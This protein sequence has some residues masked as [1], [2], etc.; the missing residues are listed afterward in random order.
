VNALGVVLD[1]HALVDAFS[2][3]LKPGRVHAVVGESGSGKTLSALAVLGLLPDGAT[4]R[5]SAKRGAIELLSASDSVRRKGIAMVLQEPLSSLNPVLSVGAQLLETLAVHGAGGDRRALALALLA[6]VGIPSGE[7]RLKMFPHQLSGGQRQRVS[8]ALALAAS[9]EV[10]IADEPTTALDA[11]MRGVILT[12]LRRLA[13]ER[14]MAVW[15]ITHDLHA[16]RGA[17]DEV[18]VMYAGRVVEQGETASVLEAPRHPYTVALLASNPAATKPGETLPALAGSV[19][20]AREVIAG[21]R[22][23]PRCARAID[24]CK[25]EVPVL[26]DGVACHLA[27]KP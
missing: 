11:S 21:C 5:G 4:T 22:F 8:I 17:S 3:E 16:V 24:R 7:E 18:T 10:L 20:L 6:E 1:G 26:V 27:V 15:L 25:V 19:P 2:L 13:R 9:P 23:H 12:L 14:S